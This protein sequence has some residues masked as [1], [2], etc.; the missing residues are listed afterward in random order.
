MI[1]LESFAPSSAPFILVR[2]AATQAS[3]IVAMQVEQC[4]VCIASIA[5][6]DEDV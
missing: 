6:E 3:E 5:Y 2:A 1:L 4:R